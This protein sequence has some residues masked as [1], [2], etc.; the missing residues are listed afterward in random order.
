MLTSV[1]YYDQKGRPIQT[2]SENISGG[3]DFSIIHYDFSGKVLNSYVV[4]NNPHSTNP[5]VKVR[6]NMTYDH[7]GRLLDVFKTIN[8]ES[9]KKALIVLDTYDEMGQLKKKELGKK[10]D[11]NGSYPSCPVETLDYNYNIRGWLKGI[12][13]AYS[14]PELTSGMSPD[15]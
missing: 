13:A 6:T 15:R 7:A 2:Q 11:L 1:I 12:N 3:T 10:R 8:D 5:V 4:Q 14:H 9:N